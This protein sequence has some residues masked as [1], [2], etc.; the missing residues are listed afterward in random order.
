VEQ[1]IWGQRIGQ[2]VEAYSIEQT[3]D[4]GYIIAGITDSYGNGLYDLWI[5]KLDVDGGKE[6][7]RVIG[8]PYMDRAR[9]IQPT[10][11]G[12]YIVI[13]DTSSYGAGMYDFWL[14]KLNS[15][16]GL[17]WSETFGGPY[18][19]MV[20]SGQ[21]THDGGY[22]MVGY[23]TSF[24]ME[25]ED[26]DSYGDFWIVK[27]D[28]SGNMEWDRTFGGTKLDNPSSIRQTQDGGYIVAGATLSYG[29]G[30]PD[31]W[32]VKTDSQ[33]LEEWNQSYGIL[34]WASA[35]TIRQTSD[36]GYIFI[37]IAEFDPSNSTDLW[38]V[39]LE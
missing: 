1:N 30:E 24:D 2:S 28:A 5:L 20:T 26:S 33:G 15:K 29:E 6:W 7:D 18:Q 16:G 17:E 23:T 39:K 38:L 25:D 4:G 11:D 8:G 34:F 14:V 37:G 10:T 21:Q 32:I 27:T 13:G 36:G 19:D 3:S 9:Y 35:V 31:A 12:G 22:I